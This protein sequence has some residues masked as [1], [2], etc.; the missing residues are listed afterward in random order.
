MCTASANGAVVRLA[1]DSNLS[2]TR[3]TGRRE[4]VSGTRG[5]GSTSGQYGTGNVY[6]Q[7]LST[8]GGQE[9]V[10]GFSGA[11][12]TST[13]GRHGGGNVY[14]TDLS[15]ETGWEPV[16]GSRGVGSTSDQYGTGNTYDS[17]LTGGAGR[18]PI[19]GTRGASRG[20]DQFD[21]GNVHGKL[22]PCLR[23]MPNW[24]MTKC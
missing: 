11:G 15:R 16:S 7:K 13:S 22:L 17:K 23:N 6:D 19:S 5:V 8:G 18:E 4:P 14:D 12:A 20:A 1:I 3:E 10:S 2:N 24:R 9:P 21:T